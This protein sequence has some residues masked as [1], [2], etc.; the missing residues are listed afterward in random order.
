MLW[1]RFTEVSIKDRTTKQAITLNS[2]GVTIWF[3]I[4]HQDVDAGAGRICT[5]YIYNL[6]QATKDIITAA[7]YNPADNYQ[8]VA[9][10]P[11]EVYEPKGGSE[12]L[13]DSGYKDHHGAV[14]MG[15]VTEKYDTIE[16]SD[17]CTVLKCRSYDALTHHTRINKTYVGEI[18][19]TDIAKD[20]L[21]LAGV[22]IGK[23]DD[24][25]IVLREG[26]S[27]TYTDADSIDDN[28]RALAQGI[29]FD[30]RIVNGAVYMTDVEQP[31]ETVYVLT[32]DTGLLKA[33]LSSGREFYN[34][35]Y[36]VT[37][38]LLPDL[39]Q[40]RLVQI[41]DMMCL[42]MSRTNYTSNELLHI[43]EFDAMVAGGGVKSSSASP[44][45]SFVSEA[46]PEEIEKRAGF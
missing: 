45:G 19:W 22:P 29:N 43:V 26:A 23:M 21:D 36:I 12:V 38:L 30:Y 6:S 25:D 42:I 35:T 18:K 40:G 16:G 1:N 28:M 41:N 24:S 5:L 34:P 4:R 37:S 46:L 2:D 39:T 20:M 3:D 27:Q 32:P 14:F 11:V 44:T 13:V 7:E 15:M 9:D 33:E 17:V 31:D 10:E 8:I